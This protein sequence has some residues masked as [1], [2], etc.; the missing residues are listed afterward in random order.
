MSPFFLFGLVVLGPALALCW[1][2]YVERAW[3]KRRAADYEKF[4]ASQKYAR[5]N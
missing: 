5:R 4:L 3:E 2:C 1:I